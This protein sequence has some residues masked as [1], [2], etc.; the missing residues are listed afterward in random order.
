MKLIINVLKWRINAYNDKMIF[1][2]YVK[3]IKKITVYIVAVTMKFLMGNN[4]WKFMMKVIYVTVYFT[5]LIQKN[6]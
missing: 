1:V 6:V 2:F 3:Q 5:I 4:V